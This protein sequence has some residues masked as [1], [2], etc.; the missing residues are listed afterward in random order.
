MGYYLGR[1][2][3]QTWGGRKWENKTIIRLIKADN[4][5]QAE[6]KGNQ[7]WNDL[8]KKRRVD[9]ENAGVHFEHNL[10]MELEVLE[11]IE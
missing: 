8:E 4:S 7:W 2:D 10:D 3:F 6:S 5:Y 9:A 11:P 1:F